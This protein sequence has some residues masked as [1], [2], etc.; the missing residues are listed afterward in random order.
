VDCAK[1]TAL[2]RAITTANTT[3]DRI[4][5][6]IAKLLQFLSASF[7]PPDRAGPVPAECFSSYFNPG[8]KD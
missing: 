2:A 7:Y 1:P 5:F 8:N 4:V 6:D 3:W